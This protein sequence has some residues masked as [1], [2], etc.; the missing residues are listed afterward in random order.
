MVGVI[1]KTWH[2]NIINF[3][4]SWLFPRIILQVL[5][6]TCCYVCCSEI[7]IQSMS[8]LFDSTFNYSTFLSVSLICPNQFQHCLIYAC[9]FKLNCSTLI[10]FFCPNLSQNWLIRRLSFAVKWFHISFYFF[11]LSK[12]V[13]KLSHLTFK[14]RR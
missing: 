8:S 6:L 9:D 1:A 12:S 11:D 10:S 4:Y 13:S 3:L 5:K 7:L 2:L 14:F